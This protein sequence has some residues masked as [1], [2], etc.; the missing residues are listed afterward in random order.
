MFCSVLSTH[1]NWR[2]HDAI[3]Y[4]F[5]LRVFKCSLKTWMPPFKLVNNDESWN[6]CKPAADLYL[7][8]H[9]VKSMTQVAHFTS[10]YWFC[11]GSDMLSRLTKARNPK[12]HAEFMNVL[13]SRARNFMLYSYA[14]GWC[15]KR[16]GVHANLCVWLSTCKWVLRF[17]IKFKWVD[18]PIIT[19]IFRVYS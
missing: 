7:I 18:W 12:V 10:F 19:V 3:Q 11:M 15:S 8:I 9:V 17:Q 13:Y 4:Y 6:S 5:L 16:D 14:I 2:T 1:S